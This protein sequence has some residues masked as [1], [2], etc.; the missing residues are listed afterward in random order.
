MP[1]APD[2]SQGLGAAFLGVLVLAIALPYWCVR[3]AGE[4]IW[5]DLRRIGQIAGLCGSSYLEALR[6]PR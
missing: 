1:E 2:T 5:R 6:R 3:I 4:L